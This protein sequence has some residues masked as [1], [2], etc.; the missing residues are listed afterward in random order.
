MLD[1]SPR[2]KTLKGRHYRHICASI[3]LLSTL[4]YIQRTMGCYTNRNPVR[5]CLYLH[6]RGSKCILPYISIQFLRMPFSAT[7]LPRSTRQQSES[8]V[9]KGVI[10][11]NIDV[12]T[13][14]LQLHPILALSLVWLSTLYLCIP[15]LTYL[16]HS[17]RFYND[18][19]HGV[20]PDPLQEKCSSSVR[21]AS[22]LFPSVRL[23]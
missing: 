15:S 22:T 19:C 16:L 10:F 7:T 17:R 23:R 8:G 2:L 12:L 13:N 21:H 5:V 6:D 20:L 18:I 14:R 1:L 3:L 9:S 11:A 4:C